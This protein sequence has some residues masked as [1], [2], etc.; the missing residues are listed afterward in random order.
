MPNVIYTVLRHL[1]SALRTCSICCPLLD[2]HGLQVLTLGHLGLEFLDNLGQV[3]DVLYTR[4]LVKEGRLAAS[5]T[6]S[7]LVHSSLG[8]SWWDTEHWDI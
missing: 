8:R 7:G 4:Q 5:L 1:V 6:S 2:D 3:R